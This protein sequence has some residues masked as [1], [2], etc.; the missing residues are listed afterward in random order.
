MGLKEILKAVYTRLY[1]P[2][3]FLGNPNIGKGVFVGKQTLIKH[4][5]NLHIG[6]NVRI[7]NRFELHCYPE[8]AGVQYE[9]KVVIED[10]CYLVD[11]IKILCNDTVTIR[12]NA[13]LASDI[14]ITTENHGMDIA[15]GVS[16]KYQPLSNKPVE[17]G[18]NCWI[19]ERVIILP[20]VTIGEWSVVAA[21]SVVTK[22][23]S[24]YTIVAGNPARPI[25][26][27]NHER[28]CWERVSRI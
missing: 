9:P 23:V 22:S 19:G 6:N 28:K 4:R 14:F 8:F 2:L 25:R 11:R 16:Y 18:E 24:P 7:G 20:G 21:G 5:G 3:L 1:N 10:G 13:L 15:S 26:Q 27:Y 17:I 12:K